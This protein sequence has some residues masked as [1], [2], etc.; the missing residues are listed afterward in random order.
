MTSSDLNT[1]Y[2]VDKVKRILYLLG[3]SILKYA[4]PV[5]AQSLVRYMELL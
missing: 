1:S 5:W 3:R 2:T 4:G